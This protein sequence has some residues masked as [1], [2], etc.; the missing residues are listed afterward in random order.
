MNEIKDMS[1]AREK[2]ID[3][4]MLVANG[5]T[6]KQIAIALNIKRKL[7][8]TIIKEKLNHEIQVTNI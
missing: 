3:I 7:V 5:F 2:T 6:S 1:E 4:Q 8:E